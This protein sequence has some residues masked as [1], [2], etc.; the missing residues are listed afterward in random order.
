M[1]GRRQTSSAL[2]WPLGL[3]L[4]LLLLLVAL[5][6]LQRAAAFLV[7]PSRQA[8]LLL[9]ARTGRGAGGGSVRTA[10][11]RMTAAADDSSGA[12]VDRRALVR[13]AGV[14]LSLL[15]GLALLRPNE[16]GRC[17]RACRV[18][19]VERGGMKGSANRSSG[20]E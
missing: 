16:E 7:A 17:V 1:V 5:S 15:S 2:R 14:G 8:L 3:M 13:N 11:A 9:P 4:G 6:T 18:L 12:V 20:A 19:G 10:A